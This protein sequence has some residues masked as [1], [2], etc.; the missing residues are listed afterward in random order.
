MKKFCDNALL[1]ISF[2]NDDCRTMGT[3]S[4]FA[5]A[6]AAGINTKLLFI[7]NT[8]P[9][10]MEKIRAFLHLNSFR[11][12]GI[13]LTT[14]D[15]FSTKLLSREI[16]KISPEAILFWGGIHPTCMPE[17]CLDNDIDCI[18]IGESEETLIAMIH[19]RQAD[20]QTIYS[21]LYNCTGV[22]SKKNDKYI[23]NG[24]G[25]VENIDKLHFPYYDFN[26]F[27][28]MDAF[29][30][31]IRNFSLNDYKHYSRHNGDGYTLITSRSCPYNC[32][33]C[34]NSF[35]NKLYANKKICEDALC[36]I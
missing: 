7:N 33:Y 30:P 21:K 3:I 23:L 19:G 5:N 10:E 2:I 17:E 35:L 9:L 6:N 14:H 26:N 34:I 1:L 32:S 22:G 8:M 28:I 16:R 25:F 31:E 29:S 20:R 12:I 27:F 11:Y 24:V 13:S 15:Y 18:F 4:L 36:R